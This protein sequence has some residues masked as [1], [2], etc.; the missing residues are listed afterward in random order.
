M[1]IYCLNWNASVWIV[2]FAELQVFKLVQLLCIFVIFSA[3]LSCAV[4]IF[5]TIK[6]Q[7]NI[8]YFT[9]L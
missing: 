1:F 5:L 7:L 9:S 3:L 6:I 4:L 8:F 2:G